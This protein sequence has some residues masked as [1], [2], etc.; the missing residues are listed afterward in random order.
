MGTDVLAFGGLFAFLGR[1]LG[2]ILSLAFAWATT[3]LFGRVPANKQLYLSG[4]AGAALAWPIVLVGV[5]VP[6]IATF[7]LAFITLPGWADPFVRPVMIALA[8]ILPL[9]VGFL[10]TRLHD[11]APT[12]RTLVVEV[13]RGIPY[14]AGLFIVLLWMIVLAPL[15]RLKAI[16]RRW[17]AAHVAIAIQPGGYATV[18][19]DLAAALGRA[20][21]PVTS[22]P[23]SWPY[24]VPG[25]LLALF[26]GARVAALVPDRLIL[27]R[28]AGIELTIHPMD[29][30]LAGKKGPLS[31]GRAAIAQELT[32]TRANQTW[33]KEA[34]E[35][36]DAL[37]RA[38]HGEAELD[39][40]AH[41]IATTPLDYDQWEILYRL[42]LQVRLRASPVESDALEPAREP[43]PGIGRRLAGI[44]AAVRALWPP[45]RAAPPLARR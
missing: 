3:A 37:A 10:S 20:G 9:V 38:A 45:R 35:I 4:M 33:T 23:A 6:G 31:R 40:I 11:P 5:L 2:K 13:L 30:A 21:L 18:V 27:L 41:R 1:Q 14:A 36:E 17:D 39:P 42:L 15:A 43:V 8:V 22:R 44:G 25:R 26:G 32:F 29:L 34:Q 12:G 16:A 7:L 19:R 28:G 24:A